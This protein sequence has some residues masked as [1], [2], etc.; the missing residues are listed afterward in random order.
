[1]K[2]RNQKLNHL[3]KLKKIW[4]NNNILNTF[5]NQILLSIFLGSH[6]NYSKLK[7]NY[8]LFAIQCFIYADAIFILRFQRISRLKHSAIGYTT[9]QMQQRVW[10]NFRDNANLIFLWWIF[11][12]WYVMTFLKQ[13]WENTTLQY[14]LKSIRFAMAHFFFKKFCCKK[15]Y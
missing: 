1:M 11:L 5:Q 13:N 8:I 15:R 2:I 9:H 10:H 14:A 7:E 4:L 3:K 6:T 12:F